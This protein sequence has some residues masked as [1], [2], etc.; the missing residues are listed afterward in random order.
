MKEA[1]PCTELS[2]CTL[3]LKLEGLFAAFINMAD[4]H[5]IGQCSDSACH[6][7]LA[8]RSMVGDWA[9]GYC[10]NVRGGCSKEREAKR[11]V[12]GAV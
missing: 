10:G 11:K 4:A 6:V 1:A 9:R 7:M 3:V 2:A 8:G 5:C 12:S